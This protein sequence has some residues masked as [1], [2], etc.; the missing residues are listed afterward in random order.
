MR[1]NSPI[2]YNWLLSFVLCLL[3]DVSSERQVFIRTRI[4]G[5]TSITG[6]AGMMSTVTA[7]VRRVSLYLLNAFTGNIG[8]LSNDSRAEWKC[9][10]PWRS[11]QSATRAIV[12]VTLLHFRLGNLVQPTSASPSSR[13]LRLTV[14]GCELGTFE[15]GGVSILTR[16][17]PWCRALSFTL[18]R[19]YSYYRGGGSST[20]RRGPVR[21]PGH[22]V[23]VQYDSVYMTRF[24]YF[25]N[26]VHRAIHEATQ[27]RLSSKWWTNWTLPKLG[28]CSC[29]RTHSHIQEIQRILPYVE[30][31]DRLGVVTRFLECRECHG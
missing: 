25:R 18:T 10:G 13:D 1:I 11:N 26:V 15:R 4:T 14:I 7:E 19:Q 9:F 30:S 27:R 31:S 28:V 20:A 23:T 29:W 3:V 24:L 22:Q 16:I 17:S 2:W 6:S 12:H 8:G 5:I 21:E